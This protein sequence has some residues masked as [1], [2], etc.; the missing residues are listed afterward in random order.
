MGYGNVVMMKPGEDIT[1]G[2]GYVMDG[3]KLKGNLGEKEMKSAM[4]IDKK[5]KGTVIDEG[6]NAAKI[7]NN[8]TKI[9]FDHKDKTTLCSIDM[10]IK[11]EPLA[12]SFDFNKAEKQLKEDAEAML[13]RVYGEMDVDIFGLTKDNNETVDF[14]VAVFIEKE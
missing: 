10:F 11:A 7:K 3:F 5:V 9:S 2:G 14:D 12:E 6:G 8:R 4:L 13:E 1:F